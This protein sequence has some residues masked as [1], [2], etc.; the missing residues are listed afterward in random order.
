MPKYSINY[1]PTATSQI[2][3][4]PKKFREQILERIGKLATDP[5][6]GGYEP[7][8]GVD[9]GY[10]R[11]RQGDYRIVYVIED[12]K[13]LVLIVRVVNRREVYTKKHRRK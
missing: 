4:I 3:D 8:H 7:L 11:V 5:R 2:E 13:L 6:P 12:H 1:H 9:R 10:F